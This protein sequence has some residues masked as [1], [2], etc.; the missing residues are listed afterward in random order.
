MARKQI[1]LY[2][3]FR[4][5]SA[6]RVRIALNLKGIVYKKQSVNL[7]KGE[8]RHLKY[9]RVNPQGL[10][11]TLVIGDTVLAQSLA[12][13]EFLEETYPEPPLLPKTPE[14]RVR[15]RAMANLIAC[16]IHPLDNLRVKGYLMGVLGHIEKEWMRWYHHWIHEGFKS[17]EARLANQKETG[18]FCHGEA[19]T[20]ADVCLIPQ[21]SN[22]N[23]FAVDL[24]SYPTIC[25]I[26][27]ACLEIPAFQ[28]AAPEN[29]PDTQQKERFH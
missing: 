22:A 5:S 10:V 15:V 17:L 24:N 25:K 2:D 13:L 23:R 11:P 20:I 7:L 3:Y 21:V 1:I 28:N 8:Q 16:E 18:T 29:Q 9:L 26:N 6:Y 4:S 14:E 19:P 12:I 27:S